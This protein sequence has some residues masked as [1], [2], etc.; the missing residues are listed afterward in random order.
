MKMK[1]EIMNVIALLSSVCCIFIFISYSDTLFVKEQWSD[2]WRWR[3]NHFVSQRMKLLLF[4][5]K[6]NGAIS[7]RQHIVVVLECLWCDVLDYL[8]TTLE[9]F[10]GDFFS[11]Y[12][13]TW[14]LRTLDFSLTFFDRKFWMFSSRWYNQKE[15]KYEKYKMKMWNY[16]LNSNQFIENNRFL[17]A[18]HNLFPIFCLFHFLL[19]EYFITLKIS[20]SY[21]A[22]SSSC[23]N[24]CFLFLSVYLMNFLLF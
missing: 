20:I 3:L 14:S 6:R 7:T 23:K 17:D 16:K 21:F 19:F 10:F 15:R 9:N 11:C 2:C 18:I 12:D 8:V 5:S 13:W 1:A 24:F 22:Q 4:Y